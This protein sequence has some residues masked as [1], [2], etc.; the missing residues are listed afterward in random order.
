LLSYQ[1]D[2]NDFFGLTASL[3][4]EGRSGRPFSYIYNGRVSNGDSSWSDLIFVP[5][6]ATQIN[7]VDSEDWTALD[8]FIKGDDYL[9]SRRGQFAERNGA[10][11]PFEHNFDLKLALNVG[12][13]VSETANKVQVSLDVL[14]FGNLL[15]KDWGAKYFVR[16][17]QF[18]LIRFEGIE[19][20]N[21][22]N[23]GTY[24]FNAPSG[25]IW[26]VDDFASRWR[27]VLGIRYIFE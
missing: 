18:S 11:L 6:D 15:N 4:Y 8:A 5:A 20:V 27:M 24:S 23:I 21:G 14:N 22:E 12:A 26:N 2:F 16:N 9:N 17:D 7:L 19:E 10:R 3:F 13:K 1:K 25:D